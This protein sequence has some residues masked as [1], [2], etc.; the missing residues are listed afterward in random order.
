MRKSLIGLFATW[1]MVG[2]G[3]GGGSGAEPPQTSGPLP[4]TAA[5]YAAVAQ[6]A[7]AVPS[8][9]TGATD[10]ITGVQ[11]SDERLLFAYARKQAAR[12][13]HWFRLAPR[14]VTGATI[15]EVEPCEGGGTVTASLEDLNNN[16][17]IDAGESVTLVADQ[18]VE[19]GARVNGTMRVQIDS[20]SGD[21][22]TDFFSM[23][24]TITLDSLAVTT[25]GGTVNGSGTLGLGVSNT[26]PFSSL[27]TLT[28][29]SLS[30]S[31]TYG[32]LSFARSLANFTMTMT[33]SPSGFGYADAVEVSGTFVSST[34]ESKSVVL[35]TV[36][37]FVTPSTSNYPTGGQ[38]TAT[39]LN[40]SRARVTAQ[41]DGNTVLIELDADGNGVYE[42][43]VSKLWS[44]LI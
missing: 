20:L 23:A 8:Y 11:V 35:T 40:G 30:T 4:I 25:A 1:A 43:S 41:S 19:G 2:C 3:G 14:L 34:L 18:C 32:T 27:A 16:N 37:P 9:L 39:G 10:L 33:T 21:P 15:V 26:G 24:L 13:S 17:D 28:A 29:S 31:G 36:N 6:E 38:L 5:N 44:E 42:M 7:L 12:L 22:N